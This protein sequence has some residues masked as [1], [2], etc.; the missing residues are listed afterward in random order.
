MI[1]VL[2]ASLIDFTRD[3]FLEITQS[4]NLKRSDEVP[5]GGTSLK[6][7]KFETREERNERKVED[8]NI[9]TEIKKLN[10]KEEGL[11][12]DL[13]STEDATFKIDLS[14]QMKKL[15]KEK[16]R[17]ESKM[18]DGR[19]ALL[20]E[21][22][23]ITLSKDVKMTIS[24]LAKNSEENWALETMA[25]EKKLEFHHRL[26][27]ALQKRF[28]LDNHLLTHLSY[29]DPVLICNEKTESAFK[30]IAE[31]MSNFI[32][33]EEIDSIVSE[34]RR[35][36]M[37][38]KDLGEDFK[39]Y[40]EQK[41]DNK[42]LFKDLMR[43]DRVWSPVIKSEK[44]CHLAKLLKACLSFVHSTAGAEGSIRDLRFIL[45]DFRHSSSDE[46]VTSRLVVLSAM[47][48][49]K[50]SKC[51]YD[52]KQNQMEHRTNWRSSWKSQDAKSKGVNSDFNEE[53]G[54]DDESSQDEDLSFSVKSCNCINFNSS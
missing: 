1:H 24:E 26:A 45:G 23:Q 42:L 21:V 16:Q 29:I 54:R 3:C 49:C 15:V 41:K 40:C 48:S 36:Q 33:E 43:I 51:C 38:N 18:S 5:L 14:K 10:R 35:L 17:L 22:D 28:P 8:K 19:Y 20:Y 37:N 7:L 47:R 12:V 11:K 4:K 2:K 31:K 44:Y 52:Y 46:L 34:I 6:E 25:K 13:D 9:E 27:L 53:S 32:K 50:E 39:E 30:K